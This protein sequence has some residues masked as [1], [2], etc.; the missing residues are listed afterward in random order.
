MRTLVL[1]VVCFLL[2]GCSAEIAEIGRAPVMTPVGSG[3]KTAP[4]VDA[5]VKKKPVSPAGKYSLWPG[6]RES[7]FRDQRAKKVGDV[8]TVNILIDDKADLAN[9]SRRSKGSKNKTGVGA[10]FGLSGSMI[11]TPKKLNGSGKTDTDSNS[12]FDGSGSIVRSEKIKLSIA[13]V[14]VQILPSGNYVISGSQ[15]VRV[16]YEMRVLR[17]GGIVRPQ[18]VSQTNSVS[19]EKIA[20]ARISYGGRGRSMEVQQPSWG[21]Q[22]VD[23]LNPF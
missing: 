13:A 2:A 6:S 19:Y 16:N 10:D 3:L 1:T 11:T 7:I 20:E 22:I 17:I 21:Q 9:K 18:D 23:L 5:S 4:V 15:E 12:K 8:L 14:I